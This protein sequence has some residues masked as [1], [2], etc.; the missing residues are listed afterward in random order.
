MV[1]KN[2]IL[3]P[4]DWKPIDIDTLYKDIFQNETYDKLFEINDNDII[5]DL[6]SNIGFYTLNVLNRNPNIEKIYIIEAQRKNFS[7]IFKN[8][9]K[10]YPELLYKCIFLNIGIS[11]KDGI[12]HIGDGVTP[13][14]SNSGEKV[15]LFSLVNFIKKYNLPR[16]DILKFDI[17]GSELDMFYDD[18]SLE[19][20]FKN[21]NKLVGELH[22][23]KDKQKS[24]LYVDII[25]KFID[26]G[27]DVELK[28]ID[29]YDI[30]K[31]YLN[32]LKINDNLFAWEYYNEIIF[33]AKKNN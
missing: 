6:G 31:K 20:I 23:S 5:V 25:K 32:N 8:V 24:K 19:Y 28:S 2:L 1:D 26:N 15:Q 29:L 9:L 14:L 33:Y 10:L 11:G 4:D 30:K 3:Y 12:G 7:Y 16:I 13:I 18:E 27:Y 22:P 17:E 21:V